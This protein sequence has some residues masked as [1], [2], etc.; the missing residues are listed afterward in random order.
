MDVTIVLLRVV[1][2]FCGVFWAG[3]LMFV[4]TFLEPSIRA[5]GPEGAK[6]MRALIQRKYLNVI[7]ILATLTVL[8]GLWLMWI[9]SDGFKGTWFASRPG[10]SF[11]LGSVAGVLALM[12]GVHLLRPTVL[13]IGPLAQAAAEA[14]AGADKDAKMA[15]V[16][17][18]RARAM[19]SGRWVAALLAVA[20]IA[21]AVARYV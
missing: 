12:I 7:P 4:V 3:A 10:V 16:Q 20:V 18:L 15:Q 17:V 5:S 14:P 19:L 6:V 1:H 9:V 21:M 8:S 11:T 2:V 13:R